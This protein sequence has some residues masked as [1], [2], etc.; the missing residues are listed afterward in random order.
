[1]KN[2]AKKFQEKAR[3]LS[4]RF[5]K[6]IVNMSGRSGKGIGME[7]VATITRMTEVFTM[8]IGVKI[9]CMGLENYIMKK[10]GL[11]MREI[12]LETSFMERALFT[13]TSPI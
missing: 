2:H 12:G 10:E 3:F 5:T 1:M 11:H 7:K 8:G 9:R 6:I 4:N 13:K